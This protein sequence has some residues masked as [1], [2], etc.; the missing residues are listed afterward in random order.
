MGGDLSGIT[1]AVDEILK[2]LQI[3]ENEMVLANGFLDVG[4]MI[5]MDVDG[6]LEAVNKSPDEVASRITFAFSEWFEMV[7]IDEQQALDIVLGSPLFSFDTATFNAS[8]SSENPND[9]Y[10]A[11]A[12]VSENIFESLSYIEDNLIDAGFIEGSLLPADMLSA[13]KGNVDQ[14]ANGILWSFLNLP[15]DLIVFGVIEVIVAEVNN[16][17]SD[18]V[19]FQPQH[20]AFMIASMRQ[21]IHMGYEMSKLFILPRVADAIDVAM[22]GR[23]TLSGLLN[24]AIDQVNFIGNMTDFTINFDEIDAM[25]TDAPGIKAWIDAIRYG[26]LA[27]FDD[28][29]FSEFSDSSSSSFSE[30]DEFENETDSGFVDSS[31]SSFAN[32]F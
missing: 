15:E 9:M 29:Y 21:Q 10:I 31:S 22:D 14:V 13:I 2:M 8:I 27:S 16:V 18:Y 4:G 3:D 17:L 23:D 19:G 6:F 5:L 11:I 12:L 25:L 32:N 20:L 28:T 1:S 26:F 7:G 30:S 24:V